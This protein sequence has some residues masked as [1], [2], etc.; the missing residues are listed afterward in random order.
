VLGL[1]ATLLGLFTRYRMSRRVGKPPEE[2]AKFVPLPAAGAATQ[3]LDPRTRLEAEI[4]ES[5][6]G[7]DTL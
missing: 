7:D 2:Q 1:V 6:P 5:T 4:I 3:Q